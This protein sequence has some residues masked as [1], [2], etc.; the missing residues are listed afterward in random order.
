M[1]KSLIF[2]CL[3]LSIVFVIAAHVILPSS[4]SVN[5]DVTNLYNISV[6]NSDAGQ[7]ANVT[8]VNITLPSSFTFLD[9]SNATEVV[10]SFTNTSTVLSWT[11]SSFYLVNGSGLIYFWFNASAATPGVYNLTVTTL[12]STGIS[13]SNISV[14]VNDTSAPDVVFVNP[15]TRGNISGTIVINVSINDSSTIDTVIFNLTNSSAVQ[16]ASFTASQIGSYWNATLN[17]SQ[18]PEGIY[19]I[20][21]LVNDSVNNLN[22]SEFVFNLT[23]DNTDP[24]ATYSCSPSNVGLRVSTSCTCTPSDSLSGVDS[25]ATSSPSNPATSSSGTFSL[26]CTFA[27]NAGNTGSA[28]ASY[29]VG[30]SSGDGGSGGGSSKKS[31]Y[32]NTFVE[33]NQELSDIVSFNKQMKIKE[34]VKLK[35]NSKIHHVGIKELTPSSATIEVAS[36]PIEISLDV[37]EDIKIDVDQDGFYDLYIKLNS[38]EGSKADLTINYLSEEVLVGEDKVEEDEGDVSVSKEEKKEPKNFVFII[39]IILVI[40]A[41]ILFKKRN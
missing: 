14:T 40:I 38:I 26:T 2:A 12:N 9:D 27:D 6:N 13:D 18:F 35:V 41:F 29:T 21:V 15:I 19:N 30:G 7:D 28:T 33:S 36:D 11:N 39:L 25:S 24:T 8:Q 37:G 32:S 34:R 16:N 31:F 10:S 20:S 22:N 3:L 1:K 5:E 17:T 23:I 4:F